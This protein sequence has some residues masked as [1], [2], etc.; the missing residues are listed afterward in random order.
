MHLFHIPQCSI[1]NR[2]VCI[3][4]L[5]GA[6]WDMQQVHSGMETGWWLVMSWC[7]IGARAST[8]VLMT[9]AGRCISEGCSNVIWRLRMDF[10]QH[11]LNFQHHWIQSETTIYSSLRCSVTHYMF[12][13]VRIRYNIKR[14]ISINRYKKGVH[15][16]LVFV[17][18]CSN[19]SS[20]MYN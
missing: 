17:A 16:N 7:Q 10:D 4:V 8:T 3:S 1:Q 18:Y 15:L 12:T 5:L 13:C 9:Q 14:K 20:A 6:L 11:D 19:F 2:N